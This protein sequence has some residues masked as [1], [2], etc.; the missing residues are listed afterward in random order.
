M[1]RKSGW[2]AGKQNEQDVGAMGHEVPMQCQTH[3]RVLTNGQRTLSA[4]L[5]ASC[6]VSVP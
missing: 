6:H 1:Q 3:H 2:T 5:P 4:L